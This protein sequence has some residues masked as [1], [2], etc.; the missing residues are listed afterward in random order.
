MWGI[1]SC[2]LGFE[3]CDG[4]CECD[5]FLTL[6]VLYTNPF[7]EITH[8]PLCFLICKAES[9]CHQLF[10]ATLS[11][12]SP[13]R[14]VPKRVD[15]QEQIVQVVLAL[16]FVCRFG[17]QLVGWGL[18]PSSTMQSGC[19]A[20]SQQSMTRILIKQWTIQICIRSDL[21]L[22]ICAEMIDRINRSTPL[23]RDLSLVSP[24]VQRLISSAMHHPYI[25][26]I[27]VFFGMHL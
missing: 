26:H 22:A 8:T 10:W 6:L 17:H 2:F 14:S 21:I 5:S 18:L 27:L 19:K 1:L 3:V 13:W 20:S 24:I 25:K 7:A 15:F 9:S 23:C 11:Q 16:C 4:M 12:V